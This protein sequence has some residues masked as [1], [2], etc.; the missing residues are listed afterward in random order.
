MK[1]FTILMTLALLCAMVATAIPA[2]PGWH[3]YTQSDGKTITYQV[4]GDEWA[5]AALTRDGL[6]VRR[7]DDGDFYYYSSLT[8]RTAMRAHDEEHRT[9][10][11]TAFIEAQRSNF[12]FEYKRP[13]EKRFLRNSPLRA[14][15]SNSEGGI[16]AS[17]TRTIPVM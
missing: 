15:G 8:G 6:M 11:E 17:G 13:E 2:K 16:P 5:H 1:R 12:K 4:V 7:A 14:G 9:A 3:T 10:V